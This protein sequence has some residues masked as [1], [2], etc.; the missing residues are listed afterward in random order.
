VKRAPLLSALQAFLSLEAASA[1]ALLG[2]AVAA[3]AWANLEPHSYATVF[4]PTARFVIDDGLMTLFFF[5][6][7][8]EIKREL[9]DGAL[10]SRAKAL[11]P[12]AAALGGMVVPALVYVLF[13]AGSEAR[14]GWGVAMATDVAFCIAVLKLQ[15]SRVPHALL[16]FVTALAI[17]DDI[18]GIA[19]I[20]LFYGASIH[21]VPLAGAAAVGGALYALNRRGVVN[22]W[23]WAAAGAALWL[24]L[25]ESGIHST[26]S[27]VALGLAMPRTVLDRFLHRWHPWAA[28]LVMPLF[29]L[30]SAG[31]ELGHLPRGVLT[32]P[33]TLGIALAFVVGKPLGIFTVTL[34]AVKLKLAPM[35]EGTSLPALLGAS[36]AAG[37]GF[38]VALFI[39][40]LAFTDPALLALAKVGIVCGSVVSG[41]LGSAV[42]RTAHRST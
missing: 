37:I 11:L 9:T 2:S 18:G 31:V 40:T 21:W 28:W 32:A 33:V 13:N 22:G 41:L 5:V 19:A 8:M 24:T 25:H 29:A 34:A 20:A 23:A 42:L 15:G 35:P 16:A 30:G 7:G 39:A 3:F 10:A 36:M 4:G 12:A 1:L 26:L 27:G 14:A 6:V 17:F 38:T